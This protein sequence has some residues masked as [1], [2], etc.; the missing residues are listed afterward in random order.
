VGLICGLD[1][2]VRGE[3]LLASARDRTPVVQSVVTHYTD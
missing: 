3:I 1:T 2:D